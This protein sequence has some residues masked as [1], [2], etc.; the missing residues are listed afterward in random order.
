MTPPAPAPRSRRDLLLRRVL[1]TLVL[2]LVAALVVTL[3][4]RGSGDDDAAAADSSSPTTS[5]DPAAPT[6]D[7]DEP[8][9]DE[10]PTPT[11]PPP[12]ATQLPA[13]PVVAREG[14]AAAARTIEAAPADFAAPASWSD[15]ASVRVVAARQQVSSGS[16]P[17]ALAGQPQTVFE[18]ELVNAS[19]APVVLDAVVVQAAYGDPATQAA[20]LYDRETIDFAGTLAP[21]ATATAVY[22]FVI[23][24]DRLG[25]VALS[26]DVDGY[27]FPAVFSGAVPA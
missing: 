12:A 11:E 22:S 16:G 18:L 23:P 10:D 14:V 9:A 21:G 5:S 27:R 2:V 3:V 7:E 25:A 17:G 13:P 15:G 8:A 20:P 4:L 26:V 19:G 6:P 24:A 1:P